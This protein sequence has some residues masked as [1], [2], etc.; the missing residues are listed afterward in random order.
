M[1]TT[2]SLLAA[3]AASSVMAARFGTVDM[4]K[5][6]RNHPNY[7]SNKSLLETTERDHKK[8]LDALKDEVQAIQDEGRKIS[9]Q[10]RNPMLSA[11][12]KQK[13][14]KDLI[15]I[16]NRF[17]AGQ[18]NLRAEAMRS[19]QDLQDLEARLLKTTTADIKK[20]IAGFAREN[21]YSLV[22]DSAAAVYSQESFD[23]TEAVLGEMGVKTAKAEEKAEEKDEGE[24]KQTR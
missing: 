15:D 12:A 5:L 1:K 23:V 3:L 9:D 8:K 24:S 21:G 11:A 7:E 17:L 14:E 2:L 22:L 4:F 19:Q 16:Q 18:Q 20:R 10:L 6:V 13:I